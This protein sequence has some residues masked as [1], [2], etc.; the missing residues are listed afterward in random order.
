MNGG[1]PMDEALL[2][3]RLRALPARPGVYVFRA[4]GGEALYVGK[5]RSL[6]ARV[7]SYFQPGSSDQRPFVR[8]LREELGAIETLVTANEKEAALLE[9]E[10]IKRERPRYNVRLRD[11]KD[12]LSLRLDPNAPWPRLQLV[13]RPKPDGARYFGP[14]DSATVARRTARLVSRHFQLRTCTDRELRSRSRPCLQHQIG[15]CPAPCVLEVDRDGYGEQVRLAAMFLSGR[16][17]PLVATLRERMQQASEAWAFERAARYRDQ[18]RAVERMAES[19]RVVAVRDLDQDVVG[20]AREGGRAELVL[21]RVRGG[22]LVGVH[23]EGAHRAAELPDAALIG[24]FV[25]A[26]YGRSGVEVPDELLLPR[27]IEAAEGVAEW[28]SERR[29]RKVRLKVPRRA[30]RKRLLD[31]AAENA[32]EGLRA[33]AASERD[34]LRWIERLAERLRL[35]HPPRHIECVDVSHL[36][37]AY[38]SAV[39]VSMRE[40]RLDR[41]GY[42]SFRVR[43]AEAGDDYGALREVIRRRMRRA[44][45]EEAGWAAPDLLIVD[46][47]RGQLEVARTVLVDLG[48]EGEVALAG[49]A[50]ARR[51]QGRERVGERLFVPGRKNP[52]PIRS[53]GPLSVLL[54]LRDEAH[55][56]SNRLRERVGARKVLRSVLEEVPGIGPRTRERLLRRFGSV[57]AVFAASE[58]AL[59]EAGCTAAQARAVAAAAES[60]RSRFESR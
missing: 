13:R 54:K 33:R 17:D 18:L 59:R 25:S 27:P 58:E 4:P 40:G 39:F 23:R 41:A 48:L 44:L 46:G 32:L 9:N 16:L 34:R 38:A 47:G 35:P 49:L 10:F 1:V 14:Y 30:E 5:A 45:E 6:R 12:Y 8:R 52:I 15:R 31:L 7:R 43:E 11:D 22:K 26:W 57:E 50:K 28:L 53:G 21:L 3:R 60:M 36:G 42:R 56:A 55:R 2:A 37:G 24:S 29:G 20:L 19:Q 51:E